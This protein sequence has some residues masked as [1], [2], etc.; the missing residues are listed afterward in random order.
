MQENKIYNENCLVTMSNM[1]NDYIDLVV[2]SPPYDN[3]RTYKGFDF[4]FEEIAKELF[5]ILKPGGVIV[6]VV[7]D[8][9]INGSQT[10]TS[11]KQALFFNSIG[12]NIHDTMIYKRFGKYPQSNRY[13][14]DFEYMFV[15]SK[16]K[17]NI[18]NGIK[19]RKNNTPNS[20]VNGTE[21]DVD[22]K[23]HI[24][25]THRR[26][27]EYGCR[28]N[29]WEYSTGLNCST[30]DNIAFNHPAIFPD[31][32]VYDNLLSWSNEGCLIYDPFSGSGTTAKVS[33]LLNRRYIA[34]EISKEYC[35][36]AEQRILNNTE[37]T[38]FG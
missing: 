16:G 37:R 21:R 31:K 38:L 26:T 17:P 29:I 9:T 13:R 28:G 25:R 6:W 36:I 35:D 14:N 4:P 5:R 34:S 10:G 33:I 22:G 19:D 2:T 8:A 30:K 3:L 27:S 24:L 12:F 7:A 1:P 23:L 18:F 32:L 15:F 11:F 20:T